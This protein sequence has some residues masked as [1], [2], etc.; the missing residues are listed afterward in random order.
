[1]AKIADKYLD[2]TRF[3]A[4]SRKPGRFSPKS[5]LIFVKAGPKFTKLTSQQEKISEAGKY[6]GSLIDGRY[7]GAGNVKDRRAAMAAC[8]RHKFGKPLSPKDEDYLRELGI[9]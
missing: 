3:F 6:C 4:L 1:M 8:I 5:G 2:R 9:K 7:E